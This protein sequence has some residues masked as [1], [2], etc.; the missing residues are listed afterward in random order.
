ME[1]WA[2][3]A[4]VLFYE[5]RD[6]ANRYAPDAEDVRTLALINIG[7]A[8]VLSELLEEFGHRPEV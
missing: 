7:K 4:T 5:H 3:R 8:I 2:E 6:E 1:K